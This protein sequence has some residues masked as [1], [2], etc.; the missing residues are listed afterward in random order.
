MTTRVFRSI[1]IPDKSFESKLRLGTV[2]SAGSPGASRGF[3]VGGRVIFEGSGCPFAE[4][5]QNSQSRPLVFVK[6]LSH[7]KFQAK[8]EDCEKGSGHFDQVFAIDQNGHFIAPTDGLQMDISQRSR[9]RPF[10]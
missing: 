4:Q 10:G 2:S 7:G 8:N 3:Q 1:A 6:E 5:P 9:V